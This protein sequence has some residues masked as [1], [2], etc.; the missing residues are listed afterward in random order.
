MLGKGQVVH[1][2]VEGQVALNIVG[3]EFVVPSAG[4]VRHDRAGHRVEVNISARGDVDARAQ[5]GRGHVVPSRVHR[6]LG[7]FRHGHGQVHAPSRVALRLDQH[8]AAAHRHVRGLAVEDLLR[9]GVGVGIRHFVRLHFQVR[10]VARGNAHVAARI[11]NLNRR[12]CRNLPAVNRLVAVVLRH[13]EDVE[14]IVVAERGPK[15]PQKWL[16]A[17][18]SAPTMASTTRIPMKLPLRRTGVFRRMSSAHSASSA[19]PAPI[20]SSGH[21]CPYQVQNAPASIWPVTTSSAITP[22]HTRITG[23]T[24]EGTRGPY[25]PA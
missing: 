7:G 20:S 25:T 5:S 23:P 22:T 15:G 11:Q 13:S 12:V 14:E 9:F 1:V 21:H 18:A 4:K 6:H 16:C 19:R 2:A 10:L 3:G 24:T 17:A 8:R